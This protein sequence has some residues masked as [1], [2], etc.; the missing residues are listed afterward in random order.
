MIGRG[1][2]GMIALALALGAPIV[3]VRAQGS[4]NN[5]DAKY[6][7]WH[8]QWVRVGG[9][10]FDPSKPQGLAQQAPLTAQYQAIFAAALARRASGRPDNAQAACAPPGMPRMMIGDQPIEIVITSEVT[11]VMSESVNPLRRIYT[12]GRRWPTHAEPTFT[13]FSIGQ[14]QDTDGDGRYDTLAIETRGVRGPRMFDA[15]G[16]PLHEDNATV[17]KERISLDKA[18]R[19]MPR[20]EITTIDHA[21]T[22]P[23][24][25]TR[26][27]RRESSPTWLEYNCGENFRSVV[28]RGESYQV[29]D[30]GYLLPGKKDQ[31][32]PD[33]RY[34]K[35]PG[36]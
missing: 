10:Q 19:D 12:D 20:N 3:G 5:P 27:Y 29:S 22:R 8:G 30:D 25:V 14:W 24:T 18:D 7:D 31:P 32:P 17:V 11:Y 26:T 33:L 23:W 21:L 28:I 13:G 36:R 15:S 4:A 2:I 1:S 6:P 35:Q 34:F 16:L 9:E